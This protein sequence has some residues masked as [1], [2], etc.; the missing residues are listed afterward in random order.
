MFISWCSLG[1]NSGYL[2]LDTRYLIL[3][4][5]PRTSLE[6]RLTVGCRKLENGNSFYT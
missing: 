3:D 5:L 1:K 4:T 2:I 6:G